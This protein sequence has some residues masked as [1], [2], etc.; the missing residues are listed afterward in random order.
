MGQNSLGL[1]PGEFGKDAGWRSGGERHSA[2]DDM[3][4]NKRI[5]MENFLGWFLGHGHGEMNAPEA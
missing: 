4:V 5:K 2:A 1:K 3:A